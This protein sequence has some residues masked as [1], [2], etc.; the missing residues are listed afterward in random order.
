MSG[1]AGKSRVELEHHAP[2]VEVF[3]NAR[4]GITMTD[5]AYTTRESWTT[6][7]SVDHEA[8]TVVIEYD[9]PLAFRG[10]ESARRSAKEP[11]SAQ[12][13]MCC[14]AA[15]GRRFAGVGGLVGRGR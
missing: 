2:A 8:L 4:S 9:G 6:D 11:G 7:I 10:R 5:A 13:R 15:T 3:G 1:A 14:G 12:G